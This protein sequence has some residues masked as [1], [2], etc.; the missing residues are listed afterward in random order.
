MHLRSRFAPTSNLKLFI[1]DFA[2]F[3]S[4]SDNYSKMN[5]PEYQVS[6]RY[7]DH[8]AS[9]KT[10]ILG[11]TL[12]CILLGWCKVGQIRPRKN[13]GNFKILLLLFKFT[14][15]CLVLS[16]VLHALRRLAENTKSIRES[17][18][19][20][21]NCPIRTTSK[22]LNFVLENQYCEGYLSAKQA[23]LAKHWED[24][25]HVELFQ[26]KKFTTAYPS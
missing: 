17:I 11:Y 15:I 1:V 9:K 8:K 13:G 16:I 25:G 23:N 6:E 20:V 2:L 14:L 21:I 12:V 10:L 5:L 22:K 4:A 26:R 18:I 24:P 19:V 7:Q 3:I